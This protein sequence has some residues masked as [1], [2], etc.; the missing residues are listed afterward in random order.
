MLGW[1]HGGGFSATVPGV[2]LGNC[3]CVA[4]PLHILVLVPPP[5]M[6]LSV[7]A[8]VR[9]V[10]DDRRGLERPL[11]RPPPSPKILDHIGDPMTPHPSAPRTTGLD[12]R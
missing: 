5:P 1:S 8:S 11:P 4:L 7:D 6:E 2:A 3:S 9:I 10:A 12:Q